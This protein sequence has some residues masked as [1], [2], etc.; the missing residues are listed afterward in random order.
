L[1]K[2]P[3]LKN[4]K[5]FSHP[6][7][8]RLWISQIQPLRFLFYLHLASFIVPGFE[9]HWKSSIFILDYIPILVI[10]NIAFYVLINF[11]KFRNKSLFDSIPLFVVIFLGFFA[12]EYIG[13]LS[14]SLI[15]FNENPTQIQ[16][17]WKLVALLF[18][19]IGG[20]MLEISNYFSE[21][22]DEKIKLTKKQQKIVAFLL[23][24]MA[25]TLNVYSFQVIPLWKSFPFFF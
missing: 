15:S 13:F 4:T 3:N 9:I 11:D 14:H 22:L 12:V 1:G 18:T 7:A 6:L 21:K 5:I 16:E 24:I 20:F 17:D 25:I 8:I 23:L 19:G 2:I 10:A